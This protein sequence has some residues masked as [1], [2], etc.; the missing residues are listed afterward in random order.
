MQRIGLIAGNGLLP[1]E[2]A[3]EAR[4]RGLYVAAVAHEGETHE[5]IGALVDSLTWVK[6]GQVGRL[7]AALKDEGVSRAVMAG[8][9]DKP[10]SLGAFRPDLRAAKL[11]A[12]ARAKARA[13]GDDAL[14]RALADELASEG[15]EIVPS[16]L[17]LERIIAPA[18]VI[19]GPALDAAGNQDVLT[20][21][22][23]LAAL[24][25]LDVGQ[26][27]VV[28][29]GV[30]LAVEAIEGTDAL[31]R[32]AGSLGS[33]TAVVV[34]AAKRGQDL[35]FDVPAVGPRTLETMVPAGVRALAVEA[36]RTIVLELERACALAAAHG[37][38]F[39]GFESHR[40]EEPDDA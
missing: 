21:A 31:I 39:V 34:K 7:I 8:G 23:V 12:R 11:V 4:A 6:V 1:V 17:F 29:G 24:G 19:A 36:G 22:R 27:V 40:D 18:G 26:S 38:S 33:G 16:T 5:E 28:E 14:L 15:I 25:P 2:F 32:R 30:V 3:R 20:G 10:R 9:I 37:L 13:M 35:R